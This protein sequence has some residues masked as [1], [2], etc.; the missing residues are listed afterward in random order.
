MNKNK[1]A[2]IFGVTGQDGS[3]LSDLLIEKGYDVFGV[4]RRTSLPNLNRVTHLIGHPQ[5]NVISGDITDLASISRVIHN[6]AEGADTCEVYNLAAQSHV[7]ESFHAPVATWNMTGGGVINILEAIRGYS[8]SFPNIRFY[9]ASSSEM[10]GNNRRDDEGYADENTPLD[11]R[12]PYAVAKV[13]GHHLTR[14]YRDAYGIFTCSGMLFNH[15]SERR[16]DTFVTKKITNYV[17]KLYHAK[18]NGRVIDKLKL[19]NIRSSRDWGFAGDYV[20][21]MWLMM[22]HDTPDDYVVAT[23]KTYSVE[24]FLELAFDFVGEDYRDWIEIDPNLIR[25]AEVHHLLGDASKAKKILGWVP[26]Y[27]IYQLVERMIQHEVKTV[28]QQAVLTYESRQRL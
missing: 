11:P 28:S 22:Q 4:S 14:L 16:G 13:A 2:I 5:F 7:G 15:E 19:G 24:T 1:R 23:G 9:Q 10:F 20:E 3:F 26:K 6:V 18:A 8:S 12:S 27:T 25:P 21:A 17:A